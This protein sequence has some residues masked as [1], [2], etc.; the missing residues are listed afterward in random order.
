VNVVNYYDLS[1]LGGCAAETSIERYPGVGRK[2][3]YERPN[4]QDAGISRIDKIKT[5]PIVLRHLFVQSLGDTLHQRIHRGSNLS[6]ILKIL[7]KLFVKRNHLGPAM[8]GEL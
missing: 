4:Q 8:G 1:T 3:A 6:E 5:D 7:Q 2:A